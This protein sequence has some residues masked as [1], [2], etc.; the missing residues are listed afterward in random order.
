MAITQHDQLLCRLHDQLDWRA[1]LGYSNHMVDQGL[2]D[3]LRTF[4]DERNWA[5]FHT[6]ENL[7]KS[8]VIEAAELLECYQWGHDAQPERVKDELA[9]VVTYCILLAD[10]IGVDIEQLVLEKLAV[11]GE[12]YPIDKAFGTSVKYDQL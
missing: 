9:D 10:R 3:R 1:T 12:K 8:I 6:P 5:Q 2:R 4:M 11:T 7:A